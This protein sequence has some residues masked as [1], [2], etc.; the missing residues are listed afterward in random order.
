M[1][2]FPD[3][4]LTF[5]FSSLTLNIFIRPPWFG[6]KPSLYQVLSKA[7]GDEERQRLAP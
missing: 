5:E 2:K 7:L 3:H 6:V 1:V 4:F